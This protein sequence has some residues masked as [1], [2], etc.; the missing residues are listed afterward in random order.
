M[1]RKPMTEAQKKARAE[2]ARKTR[3]ANKRR[4]LEQMGE[5]TT[6]KKIRKPRKAMTEQQKQAARERLAKARKAR[7]A[8][9]SYVTVD[10]TVR[11]LPDDDPLSL[12]NVRAWIKSNEQLLKAIKTMRDSKDAKDR[13]QYNDLETYLHNMKS[14]IR[15]GVWTDFRAGVE[16]E[17]KI[18]MRCA[19][20]AYNADGTAKRTVGV[21]YP[22]IGEYTVQMD[23]EINGQKFSNKSKVRKTYRKR[24]A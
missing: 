8:N 4:A 6:R 1:A 14:Y 5:Q 11:N 24:R 23:R 12:K 15:T 9:V 21:V 19:A 18:K 17:K 20:I 22:D 10:D 16:R 3:E 2:K 7:K 13:M